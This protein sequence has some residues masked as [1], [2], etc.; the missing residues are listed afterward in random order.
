M[1]AAIMLIILIF[2]IGFCCGGLFQLKQADKLNEEWYLLAKK[3]NDDWSKYCKTL[4][5]EIEPLKGSDTNDR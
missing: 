2:G 1:I 3:L 5:E 4:V